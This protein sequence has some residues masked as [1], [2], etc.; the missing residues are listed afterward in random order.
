V[1]RYIQDRT[2][3]EDTESSVDLVAR[4]W[5]LFNYPERLAYSATPPDFGALVIQRRRWANGGLIILPKLL[6][7]LA[8]QP[9][10]LATLA[11]ALV[12]VHYLTSIAATNVGLVLLLVLPL[13]AGP[14]DVVL[15]LVALPY[16]ALSARDLAALGYRASD[17]VR[18]YALNVLLVPVNIAG[19]LMSLRQA[20]TGRKTPFARTPKVAGRTAAPASCVMA[21]LVGFV[22]VSSTVGQ[23]ALAGRWQHALFGVSMA[24]LLGY[25]LARFVG[26]R[27]VWE[28]GPG[29]LAALAAARLRTLRPGTA[30]EAS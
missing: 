9:R 23:D 2:V 20:L 7:H 8:R 28:D 25:A 21:E 22:Y 12:S 29:R 18:V 13:T 1:T 27:A 30:D 26:W 24:A 17:V 14:A 6:R 5:R 10:R 3:I 15:P 11:Q 16:F 19:V 4:G